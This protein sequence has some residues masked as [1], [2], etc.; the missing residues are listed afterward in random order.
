M[1]ISRKTIIFRISLVA[2]FAVVA[3]LLIYGVMYFDIHN[4][5]KDIARFTNEIENL[6]ENEKSFRDMENILSETQKERGELLSFFVT[7]D[8][9]VDFIE[10]IE[11]LGGS[12]GLE[13]TTESVNELGDG[14]SMIGKHEYAQELQLEIRVV[15]GKE[16]VLTYLELIERMPYKVF[17]DSVKLQEVT[18][19][20]EGCTEEEVK[21]EGRFVFRVLKLRE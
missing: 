8:R 4:K 9:V 12:T 10:F 11:D 19:L 13:V 18:V 21:W 1:S 14:E 2:G 7:P 15:G 5:N 20:C 17:V 6:N 16:N 3:F